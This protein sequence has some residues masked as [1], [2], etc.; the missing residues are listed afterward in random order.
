MTPTP[1]PALPR[2]TVENLAELIA[3]QSTDRLLAIVMLLFLVFLIFSLIVVWRAFPLVRE[4][5][6][7]RFEMA[8]A[9]ESNTEAMKSVKEELSG[10]RSFIES[11][12]S[13]SFFGWL[14]GR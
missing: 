10:L 6:R 14:M 8:K 9:Y 1:I 12:T 3:Q 13:K 5:N 11:Q 7:A 4:G 2:N